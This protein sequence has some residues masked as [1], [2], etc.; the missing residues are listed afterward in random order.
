MDD[1]RQTLLDATHRPRPCSCACKHA[2]SSAHAHQGSA[3]GRLLMLP[4]LSSMSQNLMIDKHANTHL[5]QGE[6]GREATQRASTRCASKTQPQQ[7]SRKKT[8]TRANTRTQDRRTLTQ[9]CGTCEGKRH[10][11]PSQRERLRATTSLNGKEHQ[12]RGERRTKKANKRRK[13]E[14]AKKGRQ[15]SMKEARGLRRKTIYIYSYKHRSGESTLFTETQSE[16]PTRHLISISS[17]GRKPT[18]AHVKLRRGYQ[19]S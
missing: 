4:G 17:R 9:E 13:T 12:S 10:H 14:A 2:D 18:V 5:R 16:N 15:G 1:A 3:H 11:E 6:R 19:G 8:R 7:R